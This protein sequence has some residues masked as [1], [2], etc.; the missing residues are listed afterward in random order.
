VGGAQLAYTLIQAGL[1][2]EYRLFVQPILLGTG[3]PIFPALNEAIR[4][5][6]VETHTFH[7]GVVYL[8][9]QR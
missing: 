3:R 2:D 8:R 4:L 6:L 7:T 1:V 9:Y 5:K